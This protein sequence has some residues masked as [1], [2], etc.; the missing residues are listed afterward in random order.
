MNT[1]R[2]GCPSLPSYSSNPVSESLRGL[3]T[4]QRSRLFEPTHAAS[5]LLGT[6]GGAANL[7]SR[8]RKA[9]KH[10][11]LSLILEAP[12]KGRHLARD[13]ACFMP[14]VF[15]GPGLCQCHMQSAPLSITRVSICIYVLINSFMHLH[16]HIHI[17]R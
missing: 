10:K 5:L 8:V 16:I 12:E 9:K 15:E 11:K 17:Y 14:A 7:K 13:W 1:Y 6:S 4:C 3:S 2:N